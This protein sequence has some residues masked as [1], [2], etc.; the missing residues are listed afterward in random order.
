MLTL[1]LIDGDTDAEGEVLADPLFEELADGETLAELLRETLFDGLTDALELT[2][3]LAEA[4]IDTL[5]D[6]EVLA[7]DDA[8][9]T[10]LQNSAAST[11]SV[12]PSG[13]KIGTNRMTPEGL[14]YPVVM[15]SAAPCK[16]L[17]SASEAHFEP[18]PT[19][20]GVHAM[21][22]LLS[23]DGGANDHASR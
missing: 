15:P 3:L 11:Y 4:L 8:D 1:L 2:L 6:G 13:N 5:T 7:E 22:D 20:V 9:W 21:R 18:P 10:A 14:E 17:R 16:R 23:R 19:A 12:T